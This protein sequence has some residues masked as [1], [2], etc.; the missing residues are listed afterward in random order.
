MLLVLGVLVAD[1]G[2]A[3]AGL[4]AGPAVDPSGNHF[5]HPSSWSRDV[6]LSV[7]TIFGVVILIVL[8]LPIKKVESPIDHLHF[9]V[10][11]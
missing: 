5:K 4:R 9:F 6:R 8:L 3:A 7:G 1:I 2:E 11:N 10:S